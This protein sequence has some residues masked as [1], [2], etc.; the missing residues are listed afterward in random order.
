MTHLKVEPGRTVKI[1]PTSRPNNMYFVECLLPFERELHV[2][3]MAAFL[4]K[5]PSAKHISMPGKKAF[6]TTRRLRLYFHSTTAPRE[7]FT[8]EDPSTPVRE[9]LLP[10]GSAAQIIQKWQRLNQV[11]PPHLLNRWAPRLLTTARANTTPG[12]NNEMRTSYIPRSYAQA[13]S[14]PTIPTAPSPHTTT[15]HPMRINHSTQRPDALRHT[16]I[17][18]HDTPSQP[19][20][21]EAAPGTRPQQNRT[22]PDHENRDQPQ[23]D[24]WMNDDPFPNPPM[25]PTIN[26]DP[27]R[28]TNTNDNIPTPTPQNPRNGSQVEPEDENMDPDT[29]SITQHNNNGLQSAAHTTIST[30][31][32]NQAVQGAD[33]TQPGTATPTPPTTDPTLPDHLNTRPTT[34]TE[35]NNWQQPRRQRVRPTNPQSQQNSTPLRK[36][37]SRIRKNKTNNKFAPLDFEIQPAFEDDDVA[38]IEITLTDKPLRPPRR[39]FRGTKRALSKLATESITHPQEIRHPANTLQ[40][41]SPKKKK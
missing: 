26:R 33:T 29:L 27:R 36:S 10:C 5:S 15:E 17:H 3:F 38:P 18:Q 12:M 16:I 28:T 25:N 19:A 11:R 20:H 37:S 7:V 41:L 39:K 34:E 8:P 4:K 13:A 14:V 32:Q 35:Q 30:P 23:Q 6:G 9:I 1:P 22:N 2:D 31:E 21:H 40:F 24:D